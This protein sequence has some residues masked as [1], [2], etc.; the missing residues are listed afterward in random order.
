M[1]LSLLRP[2]TI[3]LLLLA[4]AGVQSHFVNNFIKN[5][6]TQDYAK[7]D[8]N[9]EFFETYQ[10]SNENMT[11]YVNL[12]RMLPSNIFKSE[13]LPS[14]VTGR[15]CNIFIKR[16][17]R[18]DFEFLFLNHTANNGLKFSGKTTNV[19]VFWHIPGQPEMY[20]EVVPSPSA[21]TPVELSV[22]DTYGSSADG[23]TRR[24]AKQSKIM[25]VYPPG[26][27]LIQSEGI[28]SDGMFYSWTRITIYLFMGV[29]LILPRSK[30][31][32]KNKYNLH[33]WALYWLSFNFLTDIVI[34]YFGEKLPLVNLITVLLVPTLGATIMLSK[35]LADRINVGK[36]STWIFY[37]CAVSN[38]VI[39]SVFY[40]T[41]M[42][43]NDRWLK[44]PALCILAPV[45]LRFWSLA[46]GNQKTF[47]H[48]W[49]PF[50][51]SIFLFTRGVQAVESV[52][53]MIYRTF[54][55]PLYNEFA[56]PVDNYAW[57]IF[58]SLAYQLAFM[59]ITRLNPETE[60]HDKKYMS[61]IE[62][63]MN[64]KSESK[65]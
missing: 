28:Y 15:P 49:M 11:V 64:N 51:V 18:R 65:F 54:R 48:L 3:G 34:Q 46:L 23:A 1:G 24:L 58:L 22:L 45:F 33:H 42:G 53:G 29:L 37:I 38:Y 35:P 52:K 21:G 16:R 62:E 60:T 40:V 39:F 27:G 59:L 32:L 10:Y 41:T 4:A 56:Q 8:C 61:D 20:L 5:Y 50:V 25:L 12:C 2:L 43:Y 9:R 47:D 17:I 57:L 31:L 36:N 19:Q 7:L 26:R 30:A 55:E 44:A 13:D 63:S 6:D 14:N